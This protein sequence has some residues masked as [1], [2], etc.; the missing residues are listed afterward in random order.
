MNAHSGDLAHLSNESDPVERAG[1][2]VLGLLQKATAVA[3]QN[4]QH[5]ISAAHR[6]A[7]QLRSAEERI[8]ELEASIHFYKARADRAEE[9]LRRI[10]H[11]IEQ[12]LPTDVASGQAPSI[13]PGPE[14]Y[15]RRRQPVG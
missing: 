11:E 3:E 5:A 13:Q 15:A 4:T 9:W 7:V 2:N 8:A 10:S 14:A 6:L 1:Q 12:K